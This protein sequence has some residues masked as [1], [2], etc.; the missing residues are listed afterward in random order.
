[1]KARHVFIAIA[2]VLMLIGTIGWFIL[3][4]EPQDVWPWFMVSGMFAAF[5]L[6][7]SVKEGDGSGNE[8]T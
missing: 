4:A 8:S 3:G 2:F 5:G 6:F 7:L 1:M